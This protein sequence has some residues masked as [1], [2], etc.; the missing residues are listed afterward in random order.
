MKDPTVTEPVQSSPSPEPDFQAP[1]LPPKTWIHFV[2]RWAI[3]PLV[4]TSVTPNQL[5]TVR[6]LTALM[7]AAAFA[8]GTGEWFFYGGWIFVVSAFFDRA[9][10]ELARL[11]RRTSPGGHA[12]DLICD[13][14]A[15]T[16]AFIGI[17]I[18][19]RDGPM[20]LWSAALG[21]IAGLA[22]A[23]IFWVIELIRAAKN[24]G[25]HVYPTRGGFDPDDGLFLV[26]PIAWMGAQALWPLLIAAAIGAPL[27]AFWT[28]YRDRGVLFS[29]R[30]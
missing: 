27:F 18:G 16:L 22:I 20:G 1:I 11:S 7:A 15:S 30:S 5:T 8:V 21:L 25:R 6:L 14:L 26:G 23:V 17:G 9:D 10:G 12:Y 3:K 28:A 29:R 2:A 13:V 24:D 4:N 19:L